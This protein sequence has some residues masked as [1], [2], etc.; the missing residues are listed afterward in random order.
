MYDAVLSRHTAGPDVATPVVALQINDRR[1]VDLRL[2]LPTATDRNL[3]FTHV[4]GVRDV[5]AVDVADIV[6]LVGP[7]DQVPG[8][9]GI[10]L[11]LGRRADRED[12]DVA[13]IGDVG[14]VDVAVG[15]P[16]DDITTDID[17]SLMRLG[18]VVVGVWHAVPDLFGNGEVHRMGAVRDVG[19]AD[20]V[21]GFGIARLV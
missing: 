20:V 8:D 12:P 17:E 7:H 6:A 21:H 3:E 9:R 2:Q 4:L 11:P 14:A 13:Q 15:L 18:V 16:Y 5:G 1:A 10:V 19:A